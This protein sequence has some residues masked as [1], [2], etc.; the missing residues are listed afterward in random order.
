M[1][2]THRGRE[3]DRVIVRCLELVKIYGISPSLLLNRIKENK[4]TE[5]IVLLVELFNRTLNSFC[6]SSAAI[7]NVSI[8]IFVYNFPTIYKNVLLNLLF[9][10]VVDISLSSSSSRSGVIS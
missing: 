3:R 10:S 2:A 8:L 6:N 5:M 7:G 9:K 4:V 1:N